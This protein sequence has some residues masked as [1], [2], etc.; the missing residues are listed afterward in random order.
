MFDF[1]IVD[2]NGTITYICAKNRSDA[3]KIY[4]EEKGAPN[5]YVKKHCLV[6]CMGRVKSYE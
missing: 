1:K 6:K 4:I 3:I 5:D 2:D